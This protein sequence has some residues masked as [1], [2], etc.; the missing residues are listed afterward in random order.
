MQGSNL[1]LTQ[2]S[3][4]VSAWN[5]ETNIRKDALPTIFSYFLRLILFGE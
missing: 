3:Q 2:L 4:S 1:H 5:K